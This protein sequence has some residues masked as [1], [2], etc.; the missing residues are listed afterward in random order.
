MTAGDLAKRLVRKH[1]PVKAMLKA[2][3]RKNL[4]THYDYRR[5]ELFVVRGEEYRWIVWHTVVRLIRNRYQEMLAAD[6]GGR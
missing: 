2:T 5:R 1:G 4:Y 6:G 3:A